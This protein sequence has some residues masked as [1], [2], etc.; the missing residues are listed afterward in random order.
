MPPKLRRRRRR[1]TVANVDMSAF[2]LEWVPHYGIPSCTLDSILKVAGFSFN[3]CG[4][5]HRP[6]DCT[7]SSYRMFGVMWN[8]L[9]F[10]SIG[11]R[12]FEV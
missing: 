2:S 5:A 3:D 7:V 10:T 11:I 12:F 6:Y 1:V 8:V 4:A 9:A